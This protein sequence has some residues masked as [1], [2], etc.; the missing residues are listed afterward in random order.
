[1]KLTRLSWA[2]AMTGL[3]LSMTNPVFAHQSD[4]NLTPNY[5]SGTN[6]DVPTVGAG[7]LAYDPSGSLNNGLSALGAD[8]LTP[9]STSITSLGA[10]IT[11]PCLGAA[12]SHTGCY[13]IND[14]TR[15]GWY[16]GTQ[17]TLGD[18]HS[19][20]ASPVAAIFYVPNLSN[21]GALVNLAE[22]QWTNTSAS[23]ATPIKTTGLNP[24]LSVY[25]GIQYNLSHDDQAPDTIQP[26]ASDS[27]GNTVTAVSSADAAPNDPGIRSQ[28]FT[29]NLGDSINNP[30]WNK[31]FAQIK[32]NGEDAGYLATGQSY[33]ASAL[34]YLA[35]NFPNETPA[36][37]YAA[38]YVPHDGYRDTLNYTQTGGLSDPGTPLLS[39]LGQFDAFAN[40]GDPDSQGAHAESVLK[41]V[42]SASDTPCTGTDCT[43]TYQ[44]INGQEYLTGGAFGGVSHTT[45]GALAN[46]NGSNSADETLQLFLHQGWYTVWYGGESAVCTTAGG[47]SGC[48]GVNGGINNGAGSSRAYATLTLDEKSISAVPLPASVWLF[49]T[50]L[51]GLGANQRKKARNVGANSFA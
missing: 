14:A 50:A 35:A 8:S 2:M 28:Y 24:A 11:D 41:Y 7:K 15:F 46:A 37:W 3:G 5:S 4:V 25:S 16:N 32:A 43:N 31:T 47:T 39:Y 38:T 44:F 42:A 13:S 19:V 40:W 36:Q 23:N 33:N 17:S 45:T 34:N 26:N 10:T 49:A 48:S 29:D 20:A 9:T 30:D 27:Y 22:T 12:G 51:L 18:S 21:G 1:M 6:Y